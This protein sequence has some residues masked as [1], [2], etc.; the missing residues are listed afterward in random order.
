MP[1]LP[2]TSRSDTRRADRCA[3]GQAEDPEKSLK[4]SAVG[5]NP[6]KSSP[7][8]ARTLVEQAVN[9]ARQGPTGG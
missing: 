5:T 2:L 7:G 6:R 3:G 4:D 9:Q 8:D 1:V